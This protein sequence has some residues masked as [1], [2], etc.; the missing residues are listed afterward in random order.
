MKFKP[1]PLLVL[2]SS[3]LL[4]CSP[5]NT[6]S[7]S[8][9]EDVT[10]MITYDEIYHNE[11]T[12][13][14]VKS[15]LVNYLAS[16][17]YID[18]NTQ[19]YNHFYYRA[20][21]NN[22]KT[23]MTYREDRFVL[24]NAYLKNEY[25]KSSASVSAIREFV[26]PVSGE[27]KLSISAFLK[28]GETANMIVYVNDEIIS[29]AIIS[30]EGNYIEKRIKLKVNDVISVALVGDAL[31]TCNPEIDF[32]TSTEP[33]LHSTTNGHYGDVHPYYNLEEKKMYMYYLSTGNQTSGPR[34][35][36]FQSMLTT[37]SNMIN[38]NHEEIYMDESMR[39]EQDLY[40]VLNVFKDADGK[41]RTYQGMGNHSSS[42]VSDDLITWRNGLVP[43]VDKEDD[44][45]KY[46]HAAYN[47]ADVIMC[48]DPD[49]FYDKDSS[50]YYCVVLSYMTNNQASGEKWINLYVGDHEGKFS[51]V[52]TK[53][54]NM[55]GRGDSECPQIKK[56]GNRWYLF[57]SVFGSGT[58]GNVGRI[59]YRV[60]EENVLPQ[61]VDWN[62]KPEHYINGQDLHAAQ[63]VQVGDKY[64][65]YGW[66]SER[67]NASYWGGYINTPIEVYQTENGLLQSKIDEKFLSLA[68]KGL[69]YKQENV[70][71]S[72]SSFGLFNRALVN[73][74]LNMQEGNS[75]LTINEG[76]RQFLVG[77]ETHLDT[78]KLVIKNVED[79]YQVD[80]GITKSDTYDFD[81][82][83]DDGFIE[84]NCNDE[85][86]L[87][88]ITNLS[89]SYDEIGLSLGQNCLV[90]SLK[91]NKLANS[92]NF[93][94]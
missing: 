54:V 39:P 80:V 53:M 44:L 87:S 56:I 63:L 26:S 40:F 10:P 92:N 13:S 94:L 45:F 58:K 33:T 36:R 18:N 77:I 14:G 93:Y 17:G 9:Q 27:A 73:M 74:T 24:E 47:D 25:M 12:K 85:Q 23:D 29:Q 91:I 60:G 59:C 90:P 79:N 50:S 64:Y 41:Y 6:S 3:Y 8:S 30:I 22:I 81:I 61:N 1:I 83:I 84:V 68:N 34:R 35:D 48:R 75:Y 49:T 71:T 66:L 88:A 69:I 2:I 42:A 55:T 43:Y 20:L 4:S 86:V 5:G 15:G 51:T 32:T 70:N 72:V 82:V 21:K 62:N 7:S 38:Y 78:A 19:G 31:I 67:Y 16:D 37:S 65:V 46:A 76:T 52:A 11:A 28:E 57:Y 89:A